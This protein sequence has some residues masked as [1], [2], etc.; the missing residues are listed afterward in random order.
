MVNSWCHVLPKIK[1][2]GVVLNIPRPVI[3]DSIPVVLR[4]GTTSRRLLVGAYCRGKLM[5]EKALT[6]EE[7]LEARVGL[8]PQVGVGG[9]VDVNDVDLL[10]LPADAAEF[11][12]SSAVEQQ[13]A[14]AREIARNV[15]EAATR[16][17]EVSTNISGVNAAAAETGGAA[18]N[19]LEAARQL[20]QQSDALQGEVGRFLT[21]LKAC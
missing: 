12:I 16:T 18:Q 20:A 2:D 1:K 13:S 7:N 8:K 19:V 9:V 3:T 10:V 6:I 5:G 4:N 14:A 17:G 21:A 11:P 15:Q